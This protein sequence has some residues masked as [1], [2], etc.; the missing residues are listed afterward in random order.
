MH[1][2]LSTM[3]LTRKILLCFWLFNIDGT[4]FSRENLVYAFEN[5]LTPGL[6]IRNGIKTA[7]IASSH[8]LGSWRP[9]TVF[10]PLEETCLVNLTSQSLDMRMV[11][12][13]T[14]GTVTGGVL[15]KNNYEVVKVSCF[16]NTGSFNKTSMECRVYFFNLKYNSFKNALDHEDGIMVMNY[17]VVTD[18]EFPNP[19]FHGFSKLI[20][21][22]LKRPGDCSKVH[23]ASTYQC[24]NVRLEKL[25]E[26]RRKL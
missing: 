12:T 5:P 6:A 21:K 23:S 15:G 9:L 20:G 19:F 4:F 10:A 26:F 22:K 24:S 18:G 3:Y 17:P 11:T 2:I 13:K 8:I 1:S 14:V 7:I 16:W 25:E